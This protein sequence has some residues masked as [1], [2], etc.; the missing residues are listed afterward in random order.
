MTTE[1][2]GVSVSE[3]GKSRGPFNAYAVGPLVSQSLLP[4]TLRFTFVLKNPVLLM[5]TPKLLPVSFPRR[6]WRTSLVS[7]CLC[8]HAIHHTILEAPIPWDLETDTINGVPSASANCKSASL[9]PAEWS[10]D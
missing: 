5:N 10:F 4:E 2:G 3:L 6:A 1:F 7:L 9:I 8:K